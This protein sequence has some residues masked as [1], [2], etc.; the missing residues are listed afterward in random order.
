MYPS[1]PLTAAIVATRR[2]HRVSR[3]YS[4]SKR[5]TP[6]FSLS[7]QPI[8]QSHNSCNERVLGQPRRTQL[9]HPDQLPLHFGEVT[10]T[11]SSFAF[12]CCDKHQDLKQL[13]EERVYLT[14]QVIAMRKESQGSSLEE[15][16][17]AMEEC[18]LMACSPWLVLFAF[19]DSAGPRTQE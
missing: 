15:G 7:T 10:N 12:C 16:T 11:V 19:S 3:F 17:E 6:P 2:G 13:W 8:N 14:S 18:C 5:L 4:R 9:C 1:P